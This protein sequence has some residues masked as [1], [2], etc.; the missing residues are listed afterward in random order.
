M[1]LVVGLGNPGR[2][3]NNTR[4]NMGFMV[5]DSLAHN[6][7]ESFDKE[8]FNGK[9]F[10]V[11]IKGEKVFFLKPQKYMNLS[12]EV[13]RDFVSYYKIDTNDILIV[14]DDLDLPTGKIRLRTHGSSGG[15]NGLKNIFNNLGTDEIKRIKI[16]IGN[17]KDI[18]TKNYVL[19]NISQ[20][21]KGIINSTVLKVKDIVIESFNNDF[22]KL[23]SKYN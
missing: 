22:E 20:D 13:V 9:Y 16:G 23:M 1:K 10:V 3:Y 12:G 7:Q 19:G 5:L 21:E 2:E 4:H 6:Y 18:E 14:V 11:N 8:K 15:H 17:N